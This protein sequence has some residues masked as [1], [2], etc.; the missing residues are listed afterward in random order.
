MAGMAADSRLWKV[1]P[2]TLELGTPDHLFHVL[3]G[4]V[5]LVAGLLTKDDLRRTVD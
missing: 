2:G 5:F 4:I 1:I 3:G